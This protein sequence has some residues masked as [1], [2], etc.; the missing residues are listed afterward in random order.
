[1]GTMNEANKYSFGLG[2]F[3]IMTFGFKILSLGFEI[4]STLGFIIGLYNI[5]QN[6]FVK[7]T[8]KWKIKPKL[9]LIVSVIVIILLYGF[10]IIKKTNHSQIKTISRK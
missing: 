7:D 9:I 4:I 3:L 10:L 5:W 6:G 1:M 8:S 2:I